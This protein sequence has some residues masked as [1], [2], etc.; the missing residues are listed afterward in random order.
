MYTCILYII[1]KFCT[2]IMFS[3]SSLLDFRRFRW[4]LWPVWHSGGP[5][6]TTTSAPIFAPDTKRK[7][8][9]RGWSGSQTYGFTSMTFVG[10]TVTWVEWEMKLGRSLV[11][12]CSC[13]VLSSMNA[14]I[15]CRRLEILF[16]KI[17]CFLL[18]VEYIYIHIYRRIKGNT[19]W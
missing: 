11:L 17:A 15:V 6:S 12:L 4:S 9:S 7:R 1:L 5:T 13:V 2:S 14:R 3:T 10:L 16:G 8:C 18:L 19:N